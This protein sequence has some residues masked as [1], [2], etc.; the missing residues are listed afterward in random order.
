MGWSHPEGKEIFSMEEMIDI[1]DLK[2]VNTNSPIFNIDKLQWFNGGYIRNMTADALKSKIKAQKSDL[3][4]KIQSLDDE[5]LNKLINLART[6]IKTLND[7]ENLTRYFFEEPAAD[8]NEKEKNIANI[9]FKKL[10]NLSRWDKET[11]LSAIKEVIS[12]SKIKGNL[13]YKIITGNESG[14]PLPES[15]EIFGKEKTISLLKKIS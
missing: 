10:S 9:F 14:L 7:F 13:L 12:E 11:I 5:M 4:L 15:L 3:Q 1:F 6:R 2:D 8:L